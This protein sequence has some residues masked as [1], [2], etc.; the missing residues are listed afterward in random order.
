MSQWRAMNSHL[1]S[2]A[3]LVYTHQCTR[4]VPLSLPSLMKWQH[5]S[6][7]CSK[8]LL[9]MSATSMNFFHL[10]SSTHPFPLL[11]CLFLD[12]LSAPSP[13]SLV[14]MEWD[15]TSTV[16]MRHSNYRRIPL[17]G[18]LL[19][20]VSSSSISSISSLLPLV[21]VVSNSSSESS[22]FIHSGLSLH[23]DNT[24]VTW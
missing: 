15:P 20:S 1:T 11:L 17:D 14:S 19:S 22:L 6:K 3:A 23:S 2:D 21:L 13:L 10:G 9:G 8:S 16:Y 7:W 12:F 5:D 24:W 18:V 4:T